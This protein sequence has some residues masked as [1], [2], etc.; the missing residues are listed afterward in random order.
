MLNLQMMVDCTSEIQYLYA[1]N[2]TNQT[3]EFRLFPTTEGNGVSAHFIL[4]PAGTPDITPTS[5]KS[6]LELTSEM[7]LITDLEITNMEEIA[8]FEMLWRGVMPNGAISQIFSP[9]VPVSNY[10]RMSLFVIGPFLETVVVSAIL[11]DG[12]KKSFTYRLPPCPFVT[13]WELS[14]GPPMANT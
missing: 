9:I 11:L 8:D 7:D 3:L 2:K 13:P 5:S 14:I 10:E 12:T 6:Y 1:R 4:Q